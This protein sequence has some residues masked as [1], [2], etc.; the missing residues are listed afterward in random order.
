ME[1]G[2]ESGT[3]EEYLDHIDDDITIFVVNSTGGCSNNGVKIG[4]DILERNLTVIV[5]GL[6][7]SSAANYIF[8]AG[9]EKIIKQGFVAFHGNASAFIKSEGW[10]NVKV[11]LYNSAKEAFFQDDIDFEELFQNFKKETEET[12][13]LEQIFL[14]RINVSQDFFD[15]TQ[16]YH[17][18]LDKNMDYRFDFLIPSA[19]TL[20]KW[21]VSDVTGVSDVS[22]A[23]KLGISVI[24]Y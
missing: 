12:I 7:A 24:Y 2:I 13:M 10:E 15:L 17:K 9:K 5:E 18:G 1:G 4:L 21:N 8:L 14:E 3:Y 20:K 6:A 19:D 16:S 23:E 11:Q 22:M